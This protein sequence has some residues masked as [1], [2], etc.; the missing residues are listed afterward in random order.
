[1]LNFAYPEIISPFEA[2]ETLPDLL[3]LYFGSSR[4][5]TPQRPP[6]YPVF[7]RTVTVKTSYSRGTGLRLS[8]PCSE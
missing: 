6:T 2:V 1:M 7:L 5:P 4:P 3:A 8:V